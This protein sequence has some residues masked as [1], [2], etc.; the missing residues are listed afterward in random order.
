MG[1]H[2]FSAAEHLAASELFMEFH[3]GQILLHCRTALVS[4]NRTAALR[5]QYETTPTGMCALEQSK[6]SDQTGSV[7]SKSSH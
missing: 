5:L 1:L 6:S 3:K 7:S 4:G 2:I